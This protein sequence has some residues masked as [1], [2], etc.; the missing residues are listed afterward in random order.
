MNI[1]YNTYHNP[2]PLNPDILPSI[3]DVGKHIKIKDGFWKDMYGI[4]THHYI[5][6]DDCAG[7]F[8]EETYSVKTS[9]GQFSFAVKSCNWEF[10]NEDENCRQSN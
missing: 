1:I 3:L 4:I 7:S 5:N 10:D 9:G 2:S 6:Y 8:G